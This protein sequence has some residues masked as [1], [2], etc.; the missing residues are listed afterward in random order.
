MERELSTKVFPLRAKWVAYRRA[1]ICYRFTSG[2]SLWAPDFGIICNPIAVF[3]SFPVEL[4]IFSVRTTIGTASCRTRQTH[5]WI[6]GAATCRFFRNP[7]TAFQR[8]IVPHEI[9][10]I[11]TFLRTERI[12]NFWTRRTNAIL[13]A[14]I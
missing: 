9:S 13:V 6:Q 12:A 1:V 11:G 4:E 14:T 7:V 10:I 3:A 5:L 8:I 2:G